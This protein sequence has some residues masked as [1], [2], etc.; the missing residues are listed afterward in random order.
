MLAAATDTDGEA[1]VVEGCA[2]VPLASTCC[3]SIFDASAPIREDSISEEIG[4][5]PAS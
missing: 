1:E 5:C 4:S 3:E 2:A